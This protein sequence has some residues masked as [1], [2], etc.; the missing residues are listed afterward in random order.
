[1]IDRYARYNRRSSPPSA[2]GACGEPTIHYAWVDF[3]FDWDLVALCSVHMNPA[4]LAK[5]FVLKDYHLL[6]VS[7]PGSK[8]VVTLEEHDA[9]L[10]IVTPAD[11]VWSPPG[12][13]FGNN[14][15]LPPPRI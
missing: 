10:C 8:A 13:M 3:H 12:S 6:Q 11:P 5:V 9:P 2:C 7:D 14:D 15:S 4:G 1:L